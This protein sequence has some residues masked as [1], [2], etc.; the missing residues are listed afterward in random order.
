[1]LVVGASLQLVEDPVCK[2]GNSRGL[3][4]STRRQLCA[5]GARGVITAYLLPCE[6]ARVSVPPAEQDLQGVLEVIG[7]RIATLRLPEPFL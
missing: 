3:P 7:A 1:M 6:A 5:G 2:E 4:A